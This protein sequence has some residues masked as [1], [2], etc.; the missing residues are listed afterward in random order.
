MF[1]PRKRSTRLLVVTVLLVVTGEAVVRFKYFFDHHHDRRYLLAPF[2]DWSEGLD[3]RWFVAPPQAAA[4]GGDPDT[5]C[6]NTSSFD[7]ARGVT[8]HFTYNADCLRTADPAAHGRTKPRDVVRIAMVGDST[9]EGGD[10]D[11][12]ETVPH[13]LEQLLNTEPGFKRSPAVRYQVLNAGFAGSTS[14]D[15]ARVLVGKVALYNPDLILYY[16]GFND[17][18]TGLDEQISQIGVNAWSRVLHGALY[19]NSL[20]YTY[21]LEKYL[22]YAERRRVNAAKPTVRVRGDFEGSVRTILAYCTARAIPVIMIKQVISAPVIILSVDTLDRQR[23][24]ELYSRQP[25]LTNHDAGVP[26][27]TIVAINQRYVVSRMETVAQSYGVPVID[28]VRAYDRD[29]PKNVF[30]D[31]VHQNADG[32]KRVAQYIAGAIGPYLGPLKPARGADDVSSGAAR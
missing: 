5:P 32:H 26:I 16:A 15:L 13:V 6:K 1:R 30:L 11:D 7:A 8:L 21:I 25:N 22:L 12:A 20:A 18:R 24:Q 23:V 2:V 31:L 29:V 28:F 10:V 14:S 19:Y 17:A 9:V 3:T 27:D 4:E